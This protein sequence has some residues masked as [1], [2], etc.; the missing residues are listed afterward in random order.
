MV[1]FYILNSLQF[2]VTSN[3]KLGGLYLNYKRLHSY[4]DKYRRI[5]EPIEWI[6]CYYGV[7][8]R[9]FEPGT[10]EYYIITKFMRNGDSILIRGLKREFKDYCEDLVKILPIRL[11]II[12][13]T[14]NQLDDCTY[15][16]LLGLKNR[17]KATIKYI[18][19]GH[20][21]EFVDEI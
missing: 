11:L 12:I 5:D 7:S 21:T 13:I 8:H 14:I 1:G 18:S 19:D 10:Q 9:C 16:V 3:T 6:F 2:V 20:T 15:N 17:T 4:A